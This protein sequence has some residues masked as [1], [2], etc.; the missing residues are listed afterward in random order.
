MRPEQTGE[1]TV[2]LLQTIRRTTLALAAA[3]TL[4]VGVVGSVFAADTATQEVKPTPGGGQLAA[5]ISD[6]TFSTLDFSMDD[7]TNT[8]SLQ[9]NVTDSRGVGKGWSVNVAS[10]DFQVSGSP[11]VVP[12]TGFSI[13]TAGTPVKVT[14]QPVQA[15]GPR[16][17]A[18]N[19]TGALDT[20]RKPIEASAHT[21]NGSYTQ[22]LGVSL[23]VPGGTEAG[24]YQANLTVTIAS[25]L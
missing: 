12:A 9:L 14:G 8:G 17:P 22:T 16:V 15:A 25:A 2:S 1:T 5:N 10:G 4:T 3:A 23:V 11:V 19:S 21:G 13:T 24:V 18:T 20:A 7:Q 6:F